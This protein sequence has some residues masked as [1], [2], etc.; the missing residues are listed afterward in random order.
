MPYIH[1]DLGVSCMTMGEFW[2][3]EAKKEGR[4]T[5]E[6]MDDFYGEIAADE[7]RARQEVMDN[8]EAALKMLQDYYDPSYIDMLRKWENIQLEHF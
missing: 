8:K 4:A 6:L 3:S 7:Q 1:P 2:A 5:H